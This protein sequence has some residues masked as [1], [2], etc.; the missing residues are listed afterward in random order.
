MQID[1][2]KIGSWFAKYWIYFAAAALCVWIYL[3]LN[4]TESLERESADL[5]VEVK[6]HTQKA[7][8]YELLQ[9]SLEDE[10]FVIRIAKDSIQRILDG[11]EKQLQTLKIKYDEKAKQ[12][13]KFSVSDM[14]SYFDN[15][16][17]ASKKPTSGTP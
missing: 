10:L 16:Y 8:D 9:K 5:K 15:R 12:T 14:Q 4:R 6:N 13:Q 11:K 17:G 1:L 2:N 3:L 7:K